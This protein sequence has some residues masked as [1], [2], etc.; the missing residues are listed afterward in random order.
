V[1][2]VCSKQEWAVTQTLV[3]VVL[4][5]VEMLLDMQQRNQVLQ[6]VAAVVVVL[7]VQVNPICCQVLEVMVV[8]ELFML[9]GWR[10]GTL[11]RT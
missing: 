6:T 9:G 5:A 11:C 8:Q 7:V 10:N 4:V 2:R 1:G 3:L